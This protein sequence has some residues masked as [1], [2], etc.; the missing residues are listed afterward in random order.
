MMTIII[1]VLTELIHSS[2]DKNEGLMAGRQEC[3]AAAALSYT[4]S[5]WSI[6]HLP[7]VALQV[8]HALRHLRDGLRAAGSLV[9]DSTYG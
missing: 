2:N 7:A 9:A 8:A 6:A 1:I 4:S 3:Q 5:S